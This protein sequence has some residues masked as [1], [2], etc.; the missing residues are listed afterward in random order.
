MRIFR[1]DALAI[2]RPAVVITAGFDVLRDEGIAY[3]ERLE[4]A[5]VPTI[6]A[7]FPSMIHGFVAMDR[8]FGEAEEAIHEASVALSEAFGR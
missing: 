3:A 5:G 8:L 2:F 4:A 6:H 1:P 7:N